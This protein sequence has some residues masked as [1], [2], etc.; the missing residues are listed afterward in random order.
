MPSLLDSLPGDELDE[1]LHFCSAKCLMMVQKTSKQFH[2]A[3]CRALDAPRFAE[4]KRAAFVGAALS[5]DLEDDGP[6]LQVSPQNT[7]GKWPAGDPG[8]ITPQS[9]V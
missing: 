4:R 2:A 9:K 1:V 5:I 8:P 6:L 3:A 7:I